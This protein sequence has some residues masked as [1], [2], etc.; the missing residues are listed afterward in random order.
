[1]QGRIYSDQKCSVCNSR[2]KHDDH[3]RGLFCPNHPDQQATKRFRVKFGRKTSRRFDNYKEAEKFL[4]GLRY[5]FDRGTFD[6]RDYQKGQPLGFQTLSEKWIA[7]KKKEIKPRSYNNLRNYMNKAGEAWGQQNI[8]AIGFGEIE[9]FLYAQD[10]SDKTRSNM[11]SCLHSFWE[12]LRKKN[13]IQ[14]NQVP[15]FPE[16]SFELGWRRTIDK[17]TQQALLKEI[18]KI[19]YKINPKIW[20]GIKWLCTYISI[21]PG[22][23]INIKERD[24]DKQ[25]GHIFIPL[26]KENKPKVVPLL[27]ED[28]VILYSF[29]LNHPALPFFRHQPGISGVKADQI[30]GP[31][32]LYKWWKKACANLG[33]EGID[34][35][36]GTRHSTALALR[37]FATPEEMRQ[38]FLQS[39]N[40][41]FERYFRIEGEETKGTPQLTTKG[42][43]CKG[44][45]YTESPAGR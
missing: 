26:P 5:E 25:S 36:G 24:I 28:I 39:T 45:R 12:W 11:E 41:A 38:A 21:R 27:N 8:K 40:K 13:I 17:E 22:E 31:R 23:L 14:R 20:L 15:D 2:F 7:V 44:G 29:P 16:I 43:P 33:V 9:D 3:L 18:F 6:T 32:Y 4:D 35:Y 1:M 42:K 10:V 19:S 30:F 37:E 34:L